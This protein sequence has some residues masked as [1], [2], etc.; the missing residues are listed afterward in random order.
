MPSRPAS[1]GCDWVDEVLL[2]GA[3]RDAVLHLG[4]PV[5]R[6]QLRL[7]VAE[8]QARYQEAGLQPG[9]GIALRL[10]PSLACI[11][12]MLAGWRA[13]A[14]VALLD[15]RLTPHE[16][17]RAVARLSPRLVVEPDGEITGKFRGYVD[18]GTR[19]TPLHGGRAVAATD[20]ALL[21]LSSGSTG[22]S[23]VIG[24]RVGSLLEEIDRYGRLEGFP[25]RGE[26]TVVLASIVH[27]LGLVGGLLYGLA[28]G[29]Q[30][31]LPTTQ[32]LEGVVKAVAAGPEPTTLLGVPSQTALLAT[33]RNPPRLPQLRRMV[34]GG[35]VLKDHVRE[36]FTK[37][38]GA[39]LG[40]MYGMTEAGVIATDLTG[41]TSPGLTPAEGMRVR[42]EDGQ[43]LLGLTDSPYVGLEDPARYLDGW[44]RTKDAGSL[45]PATG[46]LTVHGRLDSQVSIGG[47]KVDL[48]EVE[49]SICALP[50][51]TEAV[52]VHESGIEAYVT[53]SGPL[54]PDSLADTLAGR[55]APYKR[56]RNLYVL[57]ELPRTATG[58]PIRN[59][60]I[61]R[62]AARSLAAR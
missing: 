10:P 11:V 1:T 28:G 15:Y 34:T 47:L 13:G 5:S 2:R 44:L 23:K 18:I 19:I 27:V 42:I 52:V 4:E 21:Q 56:P 9:G 33:A 8:E 12:A 53:V 55:L 51:V 36:R 45:D 50:G 32:T 26:R 22:P 20:H 49:A 30:V 61:L 25:R 17:G 41:A 29:S 24:R 38:Y 43:I 57:A 40:A 62:A 58:K 39:E 59:A 7:L 54:S 3:D 48:S 16:V 31:V 60:Q 46:L 6:G 37:G 35:E 14:Q